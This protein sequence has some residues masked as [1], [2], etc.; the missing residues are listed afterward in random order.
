MNKFEKKHIS[1]SIE[2]SDECAV[3]MSRRLA[4]ERGK[5]LLGILDRRMSWCDVRLNGSDNEGNL[6]FT[7]IDSNTQSELSVIT[8]GETLKHV[9]MT[10]MP[11]N[12][13]AG[14]LEPEDHLQLFDSHS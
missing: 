9:G 5:S 4:H 2:L 7:N 1:N 11:G 14:L 8:S 12:I 13:K 6:I 10:Y 3:P